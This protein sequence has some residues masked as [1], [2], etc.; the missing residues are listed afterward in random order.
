MAA[1]RAARKAQQAQQDGSAA[2]G[3]RRTADSTDPISSSLTRRFG[4]A[5]GLA[6]LG[7][8]TFGVVSEQ[9]KTRLEVAA[10]ERNTR[11]VTTAKEVVLPSGL[12]Y[13]DI[14]IGGGQRPLRGDLLAIEMQLSLEGEVIIAT[15]KRGRPIALVYG[16]RPLTGGLTRGLEEAMTT[17]QAGG[18]RRVAVPAELAYGDS[19]AILTPNPKKPDEVVRVPPG[20]TLTYEVE[21]VRVSIAP[22]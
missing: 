21:L 2:G 4:V 16:S 7:F 6:W 1:V 22:S 14:K 15:R 17:M 19:G 12:R 9:V 20:A 18:V 3:R 11:D 8:L 13:T 10:E 5:G